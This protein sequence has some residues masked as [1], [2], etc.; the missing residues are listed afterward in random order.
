MSEIRKKNL[1]RLAEEM[2]G[3]TILAEMIGVDDSY[4]SQIIGKRPIKNIGSKIARQ[5]EE[6]CRKPNGWLDIDHDS[7][8]LNR[9][10]ILHIN[11]YIEQKYPKMS[12]KDRTD[13]IGDMYY[14]TAGAATESKELQLA[15]DMW[16]KGRNYQP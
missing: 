13:L 11:E 4:L 10:L 15:I 8:V 12:A 3:Q 5:A 6:A 9:E 1:R 2:G 7:A 16:I 14:E